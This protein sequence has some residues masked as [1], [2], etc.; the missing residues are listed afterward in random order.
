M[1]KFKFRTGF[2]QLLEG[3]ATFENSRSALKAKI[4]QSSGVSI[5]FQINQKRIKR[6][7][8][9]TSQEEVMNSINSKK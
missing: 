1:R 7:M 8:R 6:R 3:T 2:V 5:V 4:L 9:R